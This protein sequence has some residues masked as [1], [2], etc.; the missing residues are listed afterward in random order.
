MLSGTVPLGSASTSTP[1]FRLSTARDLLFDSF[2]LS[3][4]LDGGTSVMIFVYTFAVGGGSGRVTLFP[5]WALVC[6]ILE[7][8]HYF[9]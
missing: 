1:F 7:I 3:A 4:A 2:L 9:F 5:N 8:Q 6:D